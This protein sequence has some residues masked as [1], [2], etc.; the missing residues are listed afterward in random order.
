M[1]STEVHQAM[2]TRHISPDAYH[3]RVQ[4]NPSKFIVEKNNTSIFL[5]SIQLPSNDSDKIRLNLGFIHPTTKEDH[6]RQVLPLLS[7]LVAADWIDHLHPSRSLRRS[8]L[9]I[10]I[11]H[12]LCLLHGCTGLPY[13]TSLPPPPLSPQTST[14][15]DRPLTSLPEPKQAAPHPL[16]PVVPCPRAAAT[17]LE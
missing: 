11:L 9:L 12:T 2:I 1:S 6:R 3:Q 8:S 10:L 14:R 5:L 15:V 4:S 17:C 7:P 13:L 16:S